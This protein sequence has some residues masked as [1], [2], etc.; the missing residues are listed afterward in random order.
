MDT[1]WKSNDRRSVR[2]ACMIVLLLT[3]VFMTFL[4]FF[5]QRADNEFEDPFTTASF[6]R[7]LYESNYVQYKYLRER[8][9]QKTYSFG[10]LY[11][12][13]EYITTESEMKKNGD[14]TVC[15][16]PDDAVAKSDEL[17]N[18]VKSFQ[19]SSVSELWEFKSQAQELMQMMDYYAVDKASQTSIGN[20][21]QSALKD[22]I[23]GISSENNPYV[24]YVYLNYDSIGNLENCGVS[25][26]GK[27]GDFLKRVEALGREHVLDDA[28]NADGICYVDFYNSYESEYYRYRFT[29]KRPSNMKIVYAMTAEQYQAFMDG[30]E[31][32]RFLPNYVI[33]S[34]TSYY[35]AGVTGTLFIFAVAA[36]ILGAG[37]VYFG[38]RREKGRYTYQDL[39]VCRLPLEVNA[40]I[41]VTGI[42]LAEPMVSQI[43]AYYRGWF[44]PNLTRQILE[45]YGLA[46]VR[47]PILAAL[48]FLYFL[49]AYTAGS[50]VPDMLNF[51]RYFKKHSII[52]RYW[53]R[54][55]TYLK[56]FYQ[57]L[58]NFDIGTDARRIITK[59]VIVNFIILAVMSMFWMWGIVFIAVYS[60]IIYFLLKKYVKDIQD[61]YQ[62]LLKATSSIARGDL[63]IVL[64]E[65]FGV[66][67]SYKNEL[68]QIQKDFK[69]AVDEEVKS[70]RMKSELITNVSHDLKT[71]L[72]AIITYI[73]LLKV[74]G[75]T[76]EQR[77]EYIDTLD[78]KAV[79]LKVLIEDLFEV[80]KATTN[81]ITLNYDKVDICNLL[82]QCYLEY[83]DRIEAADLQ[84]KFM[85]PE[86]KVTLT[87]DP[88]KTFRIFENL[89]T[90][91]VKYALPSTRVYVTVRDRV[92]DVEIE[93]KNISRSELTVSP[94]E[95]TER[96]VRG[97]D[98]RN[99]EGSG[100]GLAI[101]RSFTELQHGTLHISVDGDLFKVLL[102]FRRWN[103]PK[104]QD[105]EKAS[106]AGNRG[107]AG[108]EPGSETVRAQRAAAAQGQ[109]QAQPKPFYDPRRWRSEKNLRKKKW[110]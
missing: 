80:S 32:Y 14:T 41:F 94:D 106:D 96:F 47:M 46:W 107:K 66:F 36:M 84:F 70:Q 1:K 85:L 78:K 74:P 34:E 64:S 12:D 7:M 9:D 51:K 95:L 105:A 90:N 31:Y 83:E 42:G 21:S 81:N 62:N 45:P 48:F 82:R 20:S 109:R 65:D 68:R 75:I 102:T 73:N 30:Y 61:K 98:S 17:A 35:Q 24:Y 88:Q 76:E 89:Y 33:A 27:V 2:T 67:E 37:M 18:E 77:N 87:L 10:D 16:V 3:I 19:E 97:D 104:D 44:L 93:I 92:E 8:V 103:G 69:R 100:L 101:A 25:S 53:D 26:M 99:T 6:I 43:C 91:A 23:N 63:D 15:S 11:V 52:Y 22:I 29:A 5:K 54:I 57:E 39:A 110:K 71:P 28:Y 86:E 58:I 38:N 40:V 59:L 4:P 108:T 60:L 49:A 50:I 13:A 79:R 72:T 55:L 56:N